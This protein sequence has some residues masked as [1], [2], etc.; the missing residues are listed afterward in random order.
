MPL[1]GES[2]AQA[3]R[4]R[5]FLFHNLRSYSS[6]DLGFNF[7][8]IDP[9]RPLFWAAISNGIAAAP[10]MVVIHEDGFEPPSDGKGR[11]YIF[12][13][14]LVSLATTLRRGYNLGKVFDWG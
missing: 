10:L 14:G 5:S 13:P 7:L 12:F 11:D 8:H 3:N 9:V 2:G 4:G 1:A 6:L